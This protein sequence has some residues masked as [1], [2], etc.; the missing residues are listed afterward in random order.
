[1]TERPDATVS[2]R[3]AWIRRAFSDLGEV[4]WY[5]TFTGYVI[6]SVLGAQFV[7]D[8]TLVGSDVLIG[9]PLAVLVGWFSHREH[10]TAAF[11]LGTAAMVLGFVTGAGILVID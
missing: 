5:F 3:R 6:V 10:G 11:V 8:G 7:G 4:E 2:P 9:F 1:M